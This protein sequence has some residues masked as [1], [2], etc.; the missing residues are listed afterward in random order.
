MMTKHTF[1]CGCKVRFYVDIFDS[2]KEGSIKYC[3]KHSAVDALYEALV[4]ALAQLQQ[5]GGIHDNDYHMAVDR[6]Q[7]AL[8]LA[9]GSDAKSN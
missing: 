3:P 9:D 5:G 7:A 8:A 6:A 1:P 4:W 2:W